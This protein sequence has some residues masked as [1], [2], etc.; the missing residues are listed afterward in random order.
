MNTEKY[1]SIENKAKSTRHKWK[2]NNF[3]TLPAGRKYLKVSDNK[4]TKVLN[5]V[6]LRSK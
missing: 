5:I 1:F 6:R 2:T 3:D 4:H